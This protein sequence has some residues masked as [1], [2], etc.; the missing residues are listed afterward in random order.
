MILFE[1]L[2]QACIGV[3]CAYADSEDSSLLVLNL[4]PSIILAEV[5]FAALDRALDAAWE[6]KFLLGSKIASLA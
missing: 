6:L 1:R 2:E 4:T 5:D 3:E